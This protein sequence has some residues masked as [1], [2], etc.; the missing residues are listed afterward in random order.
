MLHSKTNLYEIYNTGYEKLKWYP[1]NVKRGKRTYN[2]EV[3]ESYDAI[4]VFYIDNLGRKHT[5]VNNDELE[6]MLI[7]EEDKEKFRSFIGDTD[8]VLL[9]GM[10]TERGMTKEE[11]A[12]YLYLKSNVLDAMESELDVRV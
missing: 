11:V 3:Y 9:D 7:L 6:M 12:A 1:I 2:F 8:W 5:I 10:C 4:S